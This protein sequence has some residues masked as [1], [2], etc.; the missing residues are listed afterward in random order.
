MTSNT[1]YHR[2]FTTAQVAEILRLPLRKVITFEER[3]YVTASVQG[4]AGH[5]SKRLWSYLDLVR[6]SVIRS[7]LN[8]M[9]VSYL[10]V[11]SGWL[12]DDEMIQPN[13]LW[14]VKLNYGYPPYVTEPPRPLILDQSDDYL[15][16]GDDNMKLSVQDLTLSEMSGFTICFSAVHQNLEQ[17]LS[18][19]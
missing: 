6:C 1:N 5:G 17:R 4:P 10:R 16:V 15:L 8:G 14:L 19:E 13:K 18:R 2:T 11:L 9:S 7:L 3:G 12:R